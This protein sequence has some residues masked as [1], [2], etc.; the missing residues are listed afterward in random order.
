MT[1]TEIMRHIQRKIENAPPRTR[2]KVMH[3]QMIKFYREF[4]DFT[5]AEFCQGVGI[6]DSLKTEFSKMQ[7]IAPELVTAGLDTNLID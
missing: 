2:S 6:D 3:L 4:E 5:G 7:A 1:Q